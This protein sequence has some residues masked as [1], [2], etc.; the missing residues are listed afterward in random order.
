MVISGISRRQ[1]APPPSRVLERARGVMPVVLL[2]ARQTGRR[3]AGGVEVDFV[4][5]TPRRLL[6]SEGKTTTRAE[7][8][9]ARGLENFLDGF[10]DRRDGGLQLYGGDEVFPLT[11]RV[12][13]APCWSGL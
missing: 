7:S 10:R 4:T 11:Q 12:L 9:D 1:T 3:T 6:P 13:A 5:E 8:A 2:G